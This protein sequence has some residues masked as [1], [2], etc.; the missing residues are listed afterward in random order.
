MMNIIPRE[1]WFNMN[2]F[3]DDLFEKNQLSHKNGLFEPRVDIIDKDDHYVFIADLPG[4]DKKDISV[5]F[6]NGILTM[7]AKINEQHSSET[8]RIIR[9]ERRT[10]TFNRS[11]NLGDNIDAQQINAEFINGLLKVTTPKQQKKISEATNISI[12]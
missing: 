8:D 12:S 9:K 3:F 10:G 7:E 1:Q 5:Q 6:N 2:H 4:V 11:I